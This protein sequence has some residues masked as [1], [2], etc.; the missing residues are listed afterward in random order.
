MFPGFFHQGSTEFLILS[1]SKTSGVCSPS[2]EIIWNPDRS[3]IRTITIYCDYGYFEYNETLWQ[4]GTVCIYNTIL[5]NKRSSANVLDSINTWYWNHLK[6]IRKHIPPLNVFKWLT[7]QN[8]GIREGTNCNMN[9]CW[10]IFS[11]SE[12]KKQQS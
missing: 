4:L 3:T 12:H 8:K 9:C 2:A 5:F 6:D 10:C 7:S 11:S 1:P